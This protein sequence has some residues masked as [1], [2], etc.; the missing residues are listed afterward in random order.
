[1]TVR[2]RAD[3]A[4]RIVE[5]RARGHTWSWISDHHGLS[6]RHCRRLVA[7][8]RSATPAFAQR[9]PVE[10]VEEMFER[11]EAVI[12]ELTEIAANTTHAATQ[13]G[14][15]RQKVAAMESQLALLQAVGVVPQWGSLR[16]EMD[17]RRVA[18]V[19]LD[20]FVRHGVPDHVQQEI[21][22][23]LRST[24]VPPLPSSVELPATN[25]STVI[26]AE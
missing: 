4:G 16:I 3:R 7:E 25:G 19:I 14:A 24:S 5:D 10:I 1:M 6:E 8:Y 2:E 18:H 22:D 9:D 15:A 23:T 17:V 20:S 21:I 13:V 11:Y 26:G 12:G